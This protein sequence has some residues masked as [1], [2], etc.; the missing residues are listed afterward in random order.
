MR[1][2]IIMMLIKHILV[3]TERKIVGVDFNI[4][5]QLYYKSKLALNHGDMYFMSDKTVGYD[6]RSSSKYTLRHTASNFKL[7]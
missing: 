3:F 2:I 5:Y 7:I 4:C 1:E 6:W